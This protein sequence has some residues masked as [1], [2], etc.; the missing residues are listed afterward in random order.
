MNVTFKAITSDIGD[1]FDEPVT[2][3][4]GEYL[5]SLIKSV[6]YCH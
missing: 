5:F 6:L 4:I 3:S 1:V 2:I